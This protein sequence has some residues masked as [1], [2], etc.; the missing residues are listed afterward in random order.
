MEDWHL[1]VPAG[2]VLIIVVRLN[3]SA[4]SGQHYSA[5]LGS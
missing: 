4:H 1:G 3:I 5:G 2:I